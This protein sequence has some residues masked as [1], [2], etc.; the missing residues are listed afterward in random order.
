M[1]RDT[2]SDRVDQ[3]TVPDLRDRGRPASM[4]DPV[5]LLTAASA[6]D[7]EAWEEL[8]ARHAGR[9]VLFL[10]W[11][12]TADRSLS[13]QDLAARAWL[14]AASELPRSRSATRDFEG[15]LFGLARRQAVGRGRTSI[16][17]RR[18]RIEVDADR[19]RGRTGSPTGSPAGHARVDQLQRALDDLD[20]RHAEVVT[21]V[22]VVGL[23]TRSTATALGMTRVGVRLVRRR[24]LRRLSTLLDES[25]QR[26]GN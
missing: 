10:S 8:Y 22:D 3:S 6:G 5:L 13:P 16:D 11:L 14:M 25:L 19:S 2:G 20:A 4:R 1:R 24:A 17:G 9:L 18:P 21:C 23:S 7:P 12:P 15:W 26:T